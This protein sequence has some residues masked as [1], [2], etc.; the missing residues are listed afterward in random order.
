[1]AA[2]AGGPRGVACSYLLYC[3][4]RRHLLDLVPPPL[5]LPS[6]LSLR[7]LP[8]PVPGGSIPFAVLGDLYAD[9][10]FACGPP[11]PSWLSSCSRQLRKQSESVNL[12]EEHTG[13][14]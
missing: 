13:L 2:G 8:L 3:S 14:V 11:N 12:V 4:S 5:S 1:M 6:Y 10:L 7:D 9:R